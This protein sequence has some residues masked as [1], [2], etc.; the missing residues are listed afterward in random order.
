MLMTRNILNSVLFKRFNYNL[1]YRTLELRTYE[2]SSSN[3]SMYCSGRAP[4]PVSTF[5]LPADML[6]RVR[7]AMQIEY[8]RKRAALPPPHGTDHLGGTS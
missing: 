3:P 5:T 2:T 4:P 1:I 6:A 8:Q 7:S